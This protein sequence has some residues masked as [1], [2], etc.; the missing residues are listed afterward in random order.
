MSTP[1]K[2]HDQN[3]SEIDKAIAKA[4]ARKDQKAGSAEAASA[5][6]KA[7]KAPKAPSEPKRPRL[8]DEEKTARLLTKENDRATRKAARDVVRAEK[9]ATRQANRQPAHMRKVLKAAEKLG[10]L[11]QAAELLF[12]EAT[13]NL[14]Q[15][16]LATLAF[17]IQHFNRVKATERALGQKVVAGQNVQI[18]GGDPRFIGKSG[19]VFKAQRIRCYVTLD[20]VNKPIYLFTS[21]VQVNSSAPTAATA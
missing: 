9:L 15:S 2:D 13:A 5:T 12:N 14:T 19:T 17:H 16:E 18:I 11:G 8:S 4:K 6:P 1:I 21:D 20:G 10:S 3:I 7:P